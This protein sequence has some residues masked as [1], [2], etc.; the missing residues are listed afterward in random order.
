MAIPKTMPRTLGPAGKAFINMIYT[1]PEETLQE[2]LV[3]FQWLF[4]H[5][6]REDLD[7]NTFP[8]PIGREEWRRECDREIDLEDRGIYSFLLH[9]AAMAQD[10]KAPNPFAY[11]DV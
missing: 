6:D 1:T 10:G 2:M 7:G 8:L 5:F 4:D 9:K 11:F 3:F